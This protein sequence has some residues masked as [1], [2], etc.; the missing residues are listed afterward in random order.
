MSTHR[1]V[2][3][4]VKTQVVETRVIEMSLDE[5]SED[6]RDLVLLDLFEDTN[7]GDVEIEY[8]V[9]DS[10]F[11]EALAEHESDM[12][13]GKDGAIAE[14]GRRTI[15]WVELLPEEPPARPASPHV[16]DAAEY[17]DDELAAASDAW[18]DEQEVS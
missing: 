3:V 7:A 5:T 14:V 18:R 1:M 2:R 6:F 17:L 8:D 12:L 10:D 16:I 9:E 4:T 15:E 13:L 11:D